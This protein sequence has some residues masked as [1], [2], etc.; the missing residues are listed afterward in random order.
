MCLAKKTLLFFTVFALISY[1]SVGFDHGNV[2]LLDHLNIN[3]EKSRHDLVKAFYFDILGL[4]VDPRKAE[5]VAKGRKTLW[6]NAGITQFHLPEA[7]TA[8][9]FDGVITLSYGSDN[10]LLKVENN[11]KQAPKF[12]ESGGYFSWMN[13]EGGKIRCVD[14]WGSSFLL[15]VNPGAKDERGV[16]PGEPSV[17]LAMSDLCINIPRDSSIEGIVRFYEYTFGAPC[18]AKNLDECQIAVSPQQTLSFKRVLNDRIVEHSDLRTDENGISNYG[19]HIS[20]YVN[21]LPFSYKRAAELGCTFVNHRFKRQA[22][23][24]DEAIEQCMFRVLNIVD[25]IDLDAGPIIRLEHEVRS[26]KTKEG[27]KYKSCP[28]YV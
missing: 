12:L 25:P 26:T 21:D 5:N 7:T 14:P 2:L 24:L 19:A 3:H 18:V 20:M 10:D 15:I 9:V 23:S 6:A 17:P 28:F 22:F 4:S 11:L 27:T 13:I 16:Q 1:F 8:Q